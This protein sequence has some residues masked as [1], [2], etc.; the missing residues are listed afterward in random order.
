MT[1]IGGANGKVGI[2]VLAEDRKQRIHRVRESYEPPRIG[3]NPSPSNESE[4]PQKVRL[5]VGRRFHRSADVH[6]WRKDANP[7]SLEVFF[8]I[9]ALGGSLPA[10]KVRK[11]PCFERGVSLSLV[12]TALLLAS[13]GRATRQL[14]V[15]PLSRIR[16]LAYGSPPTLSSTK[17]TVL[18]GVVTI[19]VLLFFPG[20][21]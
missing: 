14:G 11:N 7:R 12:E 2:L 3:K 21:A 20:V 15:P 8:L 4:H 18:V 5:Q 1:Q 9:R 17:P 16:S 13:L 19:R 10:S 6:L